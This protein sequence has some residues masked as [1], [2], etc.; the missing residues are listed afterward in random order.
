[1]CEQVALVKFQ[2]SLTFVKTWRITANNSSEK[3]D[4]LQ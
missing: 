1:M 2:D 4:E 3:D